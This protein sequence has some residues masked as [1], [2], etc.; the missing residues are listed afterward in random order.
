MSWIKKDKSLPEPK[1]NIGKISPIGI[2]PIE[3]NQPF[4]IPLKGFDYS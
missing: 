3:F 4:K 1:I 2:L